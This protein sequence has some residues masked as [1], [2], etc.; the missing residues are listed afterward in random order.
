MHYVMLINLSNHPFSN[1]PSPQRVYAIHEFG[2]IQDIPFP[3]IDPN[4]DAKAM[5]ALAH[6]YAAY[7]TQQFDNLT[8]EQ[9]V[10][11]VHIMGELTFCFALVGLLQKKGIRCIASTTER[12]VTQNSSTRTSEF[13]FI[14]FRDYTNLFEL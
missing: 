14:R 8:I 3:P 10:N 9:S 13:S 4:A 11:A 5:L 2:T 6:E 7:C 12:I 1:W